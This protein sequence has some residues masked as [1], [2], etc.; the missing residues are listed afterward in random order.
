MYVIFGHHPCPVIIPTFLH[1]ASFTGF[2]HSATPTSVFI[3][4][5]FIT[6]F[7][8]IFCVKCQCQL[9]CGSRMKRRKI[10]SRCEL[11]WLTLM[12]VC[13]V[14]DDVVALVTRQWGDY[15]TVHV[16]IDYSLSERFSNQVLKTKECGKLRKRC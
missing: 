14:V 4:N 2:W 11:A 6:L 1:L 8:C 3:F 7:V 5:V 10:L 16:T 15:L 9:K 12:L 13:V